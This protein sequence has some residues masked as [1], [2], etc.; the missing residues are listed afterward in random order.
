MVLL[1]LV[2]NQGE[3]PAEDTGQ[4]PLNAALGVV[5]AKVL[6]AEEMAISSG[7]QSGA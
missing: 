2:F 7:V 3:C 6:E 1:L 4:W 5:S